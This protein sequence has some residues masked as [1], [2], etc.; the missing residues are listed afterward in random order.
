[1]KKT[2]IA[3]A[4]IAATGAALPAYALDQG[5]L[6]VRAGIVTVAPDVDSD[7]IPGLPVALPHG[8]DVDNDTQLSLTL[9][10]MFHRNF[11][12]GVLA[13][14][15]FSHDIELADN[16]VSVGDTKH[17]PPTVTVQWFPMGGQEGIQPYVGLGLNYTTFFSESTS[18]PFEATL[19][20]VLGQDGP[21]AADLKLDDS[22]GLAVEAGVDFQINEHWSINA[23]VWW[24]DIDTTAEVT[25]PTVGAKTSFDV[26]LDP[27]VYN[28]GVAYRF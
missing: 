25:L 20:T 8:V 9:T 22:F 19:G 10:Y 24:I 18:A 27:W 7:A 23:A 14:T 6:V 28:I 5:D 15:P 17:L 3:A 26:E 16:G 1:M 21:V 13:A 2:L 12:L 11:G 4:V